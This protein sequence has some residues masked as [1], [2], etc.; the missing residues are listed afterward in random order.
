MSALAPQPVSH[1]ASFRDPRSSVLWVRGRILRYFDRRGTEDFRAL[2]SSRVLNRLIKPGLVLPYVELGQAELNEVR[3]VVPRAECVIEHPLLP[4][5]SYGYEWT[6]NMLKDGALVLLD[7]LE[8]L[9]EAGFILKD[10]GSDNIQFVDGHP[11]FIDIGSIEPYVQGHV[12]AGYTQFCRTFLNPLLFQA[13]TGLPFQPWLRGNP[14]G[15]A[16]EVLYRLLSWP[17]RLQRSALLHVTLQTWLNRLFASSAD[18]GSPGGRRI[19]VSSQALIRQVRALRNT[20]AK[21]K[22]KKSRSPWLDYDPGNSYSAAAGKAKKELVE[23]R[24]AAL[25]PKVVYDCGCNVGDYSR[26]A[27]RYAKLVVAMDF[28]PAVV[29]ALYMRVRGSYPN[30]LPLVMDMTNPSPDQGWAQ[31]EQQGLLRRGPADAVLWLALTHHLGLTYSIP[32]E[33]QVAW[34]VSLAHSAIVEFVPASDPMARTLVKWHT[35]PDVHSI[36]YTREALEKTLR[37]YFSS[38]EV[39]NLP[40]SDRTL[41]MTSR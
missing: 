34:I 7:V 21:L 32:L 14:A 17:T 39:V 33:Q 4:F 38:M 3:S 9:L 1:S 24:L 16:P 2:T 20:V 10:G 31:R 18:S 12:W 6:F 37:Q 41:Y 30:I 13:L 25:S 8:E 35:D 19:P 27:A 23:A 11:V 29:D 15:I 26:C 5:V 22:V 36:S 40:G 28:D